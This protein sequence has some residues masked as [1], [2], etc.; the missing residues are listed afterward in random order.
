MG[1][2]VAAAV[3]AAAVQDRSQGEALDRSFQDATEDMVGVITVHQ[4]YQGTR[5]TERHKSPAFR[6]AST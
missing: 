2:L 6:F 4:R 5:V 1:S 3:T